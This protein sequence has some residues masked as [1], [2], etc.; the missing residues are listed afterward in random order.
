MNEEEYFKKFSSAILSFTTN[1]FS[2]I[3]L[4]I[5]ELEDYV[6]E[7]KRFF[8]TLTHK[9]VSTLEASN[10][11][12]R[13][14]E[15]K[16]NYNSSL[17]ILLRSAIA[18]I[19]LAEY[20][21]KRGKTDKERTELIPRIYFDHVD[22]MIDSLN[23]AARKAYG[24]NDQEV[25]DKIRMIKESKKQYFD[26]DGKPKLNPIRTSPFT[27]TFKMFSEISNPLS[28]EYDLL[29]RS[30][31][32]YSQFSKFEHFGDLTFHLVHR[33]FEEKQKE[34]ILYD[35]YDAVRMI[36]FALTNYMNLWDDLPISTKKTVQELTSEINQFHPSKI[37][38]T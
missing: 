20:V 31:D 29:R 6:N 36:C 18:D 22:N 12:I 25:D 17:F 28:Q 26:S 1:Y 9:T 33:A 38:Y 24:W 19:I 32:L 2:N 4:K 8:Y 15:T 34:T 11:F 16:S 23:R 10:I 5:V 3:V 7:P 27:L 30:F 13:N 21:I 37:K 35:L 14:F